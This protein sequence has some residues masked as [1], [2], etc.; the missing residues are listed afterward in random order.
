M[1]LHAESRFPSVPTV[2]VILLSAFGLC[3]V[4]RADGQSPA[5]NWAWMGGSSTA[6][7]CPLLTPCAQA[8]GVYGVE[9]QPAAGNLPGYRT[10]G[11]TW[12]GSDGR[13]WLF[14]G[15]GVDGGGNF[16]LLDDLWAF[17]PKLG[18]HGRWAWMGGH[19]IASM[20]K[21]G[22]YGTQYQADAANLPG[23]R[24]VSGTWIDAGGRLWLFG[25]FGMDSKATMGLLN[26]L[27]VF[28]PAVGAHGEWTWISG[29]NTL[30]AFTY[31]GIA[32]VYGTEYQFAATN[33]PGSRNVPICW[34]DTAGRMWLFSGTGFDSTDS[35]V[36]LGDLWEFD[37]AQGAHGEW[38]WMGGSNVGVDW[39][40]PGK[41]GQEY[42]FDAA[43]LPGYRQAPAHWQDA[44]GALWLFGGL[45]TD[46]GGQG[47]PLNEL[48]KFDP[49]S[50]SHGEWAWTGGDSTITDFGV[51][52][53][54]PGQRGVFGP[55]YQFADPYIP[56]AR[57]FTNHW[58][59]LKGRLWLLDGSG[60]A[61][62]GA[63]DLLN[64][65]WV[66]DPAEGAHG[67]WAWMGGNDTLLCEGQGCHGRAGVY[68]T[69]YTFDRANAPGGRT[70]G[71]TWTDADGNL[72]LFSSWGYDSTGTQGALN[73]MWEFRFFTPQSISFSSLRSTLTYGAPAITLSASASS[74]LPVAY[75]VKGPAKL[76]GTH[77]V[78]IT[79][80]GSL[81]VIASQSG[82]AKFGAAPDVKQTIWISKAPLTIAAT[83]VTVPYGS[84]I[85]A[86]GWTPT[87][88][89]NGDSVSSAL[90]GAPALATTAT[91]TSAPGVYTISVAQDT[92]AAD[93]YHFKFKSGRLTIEPPSTASA[94]TGTG[95][96][97]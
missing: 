24:S 56:G 58:T 83:D 46:S 6:I 8:A 30:P 28:D 15:Y 53:N 40:T 95:S 29:S 75:T 92:L 50:G 19:K 26:D 45:G 80:A 74:G 14:G 27:W 9:Y 17:D 7:G 16:G 2:L 49:S 48:W 10:G 61:R 76:T 63:R 81:A 96:P 13:L 68:G 86:L 69:E 39:T 62:H 78:T 71:Q 87:G 33:A 90:T 43:N 85:P 77:T 97:R 64:D 82:D 34:T 21:W 91:S 44:N 37:P 84:A 5:G 88:F 38:A 4:P 55:E 11:A 51:Q 25:G 65:L 20:G 12:T 79:G 73:D 72:W 31:S 35:W 70:N 42:Q 89:V 41:Y 60:V 32:G 47:G 54:Y 57:A 23:A 22:E 94:Q 1:R 52:G 67:Q 36:N 3:A 18:A 59:D 66:F 93:N